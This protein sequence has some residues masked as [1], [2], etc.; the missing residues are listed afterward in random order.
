MTDESI[1]PQPRSERAHYVREPAFWVAG[2][3]DMG[4]RHRT[5]QDAMCLAVRSEPR[6]E[7]MLA[8]ADG[9]TTAEGSELA[10]LVAAETVVQQLIERVGEGTAPNLAFVQAFSAANEEVLGAADEPSACTLLAAMVQ[11]G[12]IA[13]GNVGDSRAYWLSDDGSTEL[14]STDDSMAQARIMLGMSR[15]E[16]EQSSQ[17]HAITKWLGRQATNVTPSVITA[18]PQT[19]GWLLL[20][21]DGLWNY[22]SSPE[23]MSALF[24]EHLGR[25]SGPAALAESLV[26][27]ANEQGGKDNITVVLARVEH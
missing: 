10:S 8:I 19:N 18:Q 22:A 25:T 14:L 27:W 5:N 26:N 6:N 3:S 7:A 12:L 1:T 4:R 24:S 15:D 16:A 17:A 23:D 9:V 2:C 13:V 11:P 20:C 21:T